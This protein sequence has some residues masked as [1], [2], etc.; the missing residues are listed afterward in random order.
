MFKS[1]L[2]LLL[3]VFVFVHASSHSE[4]PG[5]AA[6]PN[7]DI[8]DL[9]AFRSYESGKDDHIIFVMNV[10]PLQAPFAGPNYFSLSDRHYFEIY[11]D[12]DGDGIEDVTFQFQPGQRMAG[13]IQ[14]YTTVDP[15]DHLGDACPPTQ[16]IKENV[17]L[18]AGIEL[19]IAGQSVS[20]PLKFVGPI[21][22]SDNSA[23]NWFEYYNL[24]KITG[25]RTTGA[26][27]P[28]SESGTGTS[29]FIKPFDYAGEKTFGDAAAYESYASQYHYTIDIPDCQGV[30]QQGKV[31]VGQRKESFS[32]NLGGI[33]DLINFIPVPGIAGA[34]QNDI[35]NDALNVFNV[36]SFVL[37]L[38]I[39]CVISSGGSDTIGIWSATRDLL[40]FENGTHTPTRQ[41][42]RMGNPLVNEVVIGLRD[43]V[44]FNA[45][46]PV[47]DAA[48]GFA[49]YVAYPT[50]P[51]IINLL[52]KDAVNSALATNFTDLA[53]TNFP[54]NDLITAFLTGVPGLNQIPSSIAAEYIRLN[55]SI[56]S[57][58]AAS[59][60]NMGVIAGDNAGFPNGRR[61]G[62]DVVDIALRVMM[63]ALCHLNIDC[64]ATDAV[65]GNVEFLDGAPQ[66]AAQFDS[67][68]PF[69]TTPL[70]GYQTASPRSSQLS[71]RRRW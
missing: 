1:L 8:T 12:Q 17:T 26:V 45:D 37:E 46:Q 32:V 20:V 55:T 5:T 62:D 42:S 24:N 71:S 34:I 11:L 53:P 29:Q 68:F 10:Q 60:H 40:H 52:F 39:S 64:N 56:A 16:L 65:V 57:V 41:F 44:L 13:N 22:S 63:G 27:S 3:I 9:Y 15:Q 70:P 6:L 33:F 58:P 69:L 28:I 23:L 61:P 14:T 54:R 25:L 43:K 35:A 49:T 36:N 2:L 30:T 19:D 66:N 21:S 4:A 31:F 48:N 47:N 67:V 59:Q 18:N 38:P 51:A 7:A 50:L